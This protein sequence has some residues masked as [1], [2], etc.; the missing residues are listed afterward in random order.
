[1]E[2]ETQKRWEFEE[3]LVTGRSCIER[4]EF[5]PAI[6]C[7]LLALKLAEETQDQTQATVAILCLGDAY[8]LKNEIQIAIEHYEIALVIAKERVDKQEE[9]NAY[10]G[11]GSAY[12]ANNDIE[13]AIECYENALGIAI[14][15]RR[16]RK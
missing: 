3:Q 2:N 6:E 4:N 10:I 13:T 11:L 14:N 7:F 12:G 8:R 9:T 15:P 1:M 16:Q 5:Q